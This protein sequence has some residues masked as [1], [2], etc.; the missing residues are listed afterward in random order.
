MTANNYPCHTMQGTSIYV[1]CPSVFEESITFPTASLCPTG[2]YHDGT[3]CRLFNWSSVQPAFGDVGFL[4]RSANKNMHWS[5]TNKPM[6]G[7]SYDPLPAE[8]ADRNAHECD[9]SYS[10]TKRFSV[11]DVQRLEEADTNIQYDNLTD[12]NV[13]LDPQNAHVQPGGSQNPSEATHGAYH[14]H[15]YPEWD[16]GDYADYIIGYA[17]DGVPIMGRNSKLANGQTASSSYALRDGQDGRYHMDYEYKGTGT[18]DEFNGGLVTIDGTST[19]AYFSTST[20]PYLFRNF[21]GDYNGA[22][23]N[24]PS[25]CDKCYTPQCP[26][27]SNVA[28][29]CSNPSVSISMDTGSDNFTL[30]ANNYPCHDMVG[31]T[32]YVVCPSEHS[33]S[34]TF[35]NPNLCSA[36]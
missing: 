3:N 11:V 19:Y 4:G 6:E 14:Y 24:L 12:L 29:T 7:V 31:P 9:S 17:K 28:A 35:P 8:C 16:N 21:H 32:V 5:S 36:G 20:Y 2:Y 26:G 22:G 25:T 33:E 15:G 1:V 13:G 30:T 18:L 34:M 23:T 10:G 27:N